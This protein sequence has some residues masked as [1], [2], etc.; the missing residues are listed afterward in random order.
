MLPVIPEASAR[1]AGGIQNQQSVFLSFRGRPRGLRA[2]PGIGL[3]FAGFAKP[4]D[5]RHPWRSRYAPPWAFAFAILQTQSGSPAMKPQVPRN[6]GEGDSCRGTARI[7]MVL[8]IPGRPR[9]L[10][11]ASKISNQYFCH[12]G[13]ARAVCGRNPESVL[14]LQGLRIRNDDEFSSRLHET[15]RDTTLIGRCRHAGPVVQPDP[16]VRCNA[17]RG[18][19][20]F[21]RRSLHHLHQVRRVDVLLERRL[22]LRGRK[23]QIMPRRDHRLVQWLTVDAPTEQ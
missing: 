21:W 20:L 15:C 10:P 23:G 6:D 13:G 9:G 2:E 22:Y 19:V 1:F 8:V 16:P 17:Q 7:G 5:L 3:A 18:S 14:R 11:V 12:S 4:I